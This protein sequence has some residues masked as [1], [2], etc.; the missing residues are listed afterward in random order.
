MQWEIFFYVGIEG[1][2]YEKR[3]ILIDDN[4]K[5][6]KYVNLYGRPDQ[7]KIKNK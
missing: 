2:D 4:F 6:L 5:C 1:Y 7:P 3:E